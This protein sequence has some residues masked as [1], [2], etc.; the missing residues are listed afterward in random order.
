MKDYMVFFKSIKNSWYFRPRAIAW[1]RLF[2]DFVP[3]DEPERFKAFFRISPTL[4]DHI[5]NILPDD[6]VTKP[7]AG[8]QNLPNCKLLVHRQVVMALR[9]FV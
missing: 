3:S 9:L 8:L 7:P 2:F 5:C 1:S 4:F 6:M